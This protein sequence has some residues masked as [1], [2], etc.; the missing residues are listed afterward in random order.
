[1]GFNLP[2][3]TSEE[4]SKLKTGID[5]QTKNR[6]GEREKEIKLKKKKKRGAGG[7]CQPP[8]LGGEDVA[9]PRRSPLL[10]DAVAQRFLLLQGRHGQAQVLLQ[11]LDLPLRAHL[12]VIQLGVD[13]LVFP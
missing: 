11:L 4:R 3:P 2:L 1:M 5:K 9:A 12:D 10:A 6:P 7:T 8:A 13:V